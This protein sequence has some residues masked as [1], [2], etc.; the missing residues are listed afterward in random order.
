[1]WDS[2][3][4]AVDEA[5]D[6]VEATVQEED[7]VVVVEVRVL[8]AVVVEVEVREVEV[9]VVTAGFLKAHSFWS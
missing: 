2:V 6:V 9:D 8:V 3:V 1:M 5:V 7:T 4:V